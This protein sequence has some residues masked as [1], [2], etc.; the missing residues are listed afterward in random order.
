MQRYNLSKRLSDA[1]DLDS[2]LPGEFVIYISRDQSGEVSDEWESY[3]STDNE[4]L[5]K[6]IER[7][8]C[9]SPIM[10]VYVLKYV[11]RSVDTFF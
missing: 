2:D 6:R 3:C 9:A 8:D 1:D 5:I 11:V 4:Q 10:I 7:E